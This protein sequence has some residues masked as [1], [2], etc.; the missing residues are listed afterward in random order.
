[1]QPFPFVPSHSPA[2]EPAPF[3]LTAPQGLCPLW[4][5]QVPLL[6]CARHGTARCHALPR[7]RLCCS[8]HASPWLCIFLLRRHLPAG[9]ACRLLS[10]R[11]LLTRGDTGRA[12][13]LAKARFLPYI[14]RVFPHLPFFF[15]ILS[16]RVGMG[17]DASLRQRTTFPSMRRRGE[18]RVLL[19][20]HAGKC[21][22]AARSVG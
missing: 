4:A 8:S 11:S 5:A 9:S 10:Q 17:R 6:V 1:M 21:S 16:C 18:Q 19:R 7:G 14:V 12:R 3:L 2:A 22:S 13:W 15:F 20:L